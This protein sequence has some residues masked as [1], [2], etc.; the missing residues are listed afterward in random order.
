[1]A[2]ACFKYSPLREH[3]WNIWIKSPLAYNEDYIIIN[4]E[5]WNT[6]TTHQT[7]NYAILRTPYGEGN[8]K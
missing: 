3:P 1:M 4:K 7:N 6:L 8:E 2:D 5:I